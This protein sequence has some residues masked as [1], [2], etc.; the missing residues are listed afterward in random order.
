MILLGPER[1]FRLVESATRMMEHFAHPGDCESYHGKNRTLHPGRCVDP[2]KV[3][4]AH[5]GE[6]KGKKPW[7]DAARNSRKKDRRNKENEGYRVAQDALQS[8]PDN[9]HCS[10]GAGG[11]QIT[12]IP[13]ETG[14][15]DRLQ[16]TALQP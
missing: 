10:H 9:K 13:L 8:Q 2:R 16:E 5:K 3:E 12:D 14:R 11:E 4:R 15:E 7:T 1:F 6:D